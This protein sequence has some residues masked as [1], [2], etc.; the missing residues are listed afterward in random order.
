MGN[1]QA[2]DGT[3]ISASFA[4]PWALDFDAAGN[5]YVSEPQAQV[6]RKISPEGVVTTIAGTAN[7]RGLADGS[8]T[9]ATFSS[10]Y[11]IAVNRDANLLYVADGDNNLIRT[12]NLGLD[13]TDQNYVTTLAGSPSGQSGDQDGTGSNALLHLPLISRWIVQVTL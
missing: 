4:Y 6:I 7:S 10:P 2:Q 5:L 12:I 8:I 11:G 13:P 9:S 1:P 3:G